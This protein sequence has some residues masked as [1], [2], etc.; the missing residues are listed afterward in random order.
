MRAS[1]SSTAH[2]VVRLPTSMSEWIKSVQT[3]VARGWSVIAHPKAMGLASWP[4]RCQPTS[5]VERHGSWRLCHDLSWPLPGTVEGVTSPNAAESDIRRAKFA[6]F[7]DLAVAASC[8]L[9]AGVPIKV[10]K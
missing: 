7:N 4:V 5:M 8:M 1:S 2:T 10:A 6:A 9:V 3:E